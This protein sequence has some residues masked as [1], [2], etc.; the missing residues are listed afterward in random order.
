MG[1]QETFLGIPLEGPK[2]LILAPKRQFPPNKSA[3]KAYGSFSFLLAS[4]VPSGLDA[5][6]RK[7]SI[8]APFHPFKT[9]MHAFYVCFHEESDFRGPEAWNHLFSFGF[10]YISIVQCTST[11]Q[12]VHD[13]STQCSHYTHIIFFRWY[14]T[15]ETGRDDIIAKDIWAG[16]Y[17]VHM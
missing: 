10:F 13:I 4:K 2:I 11:L 17:N 16:N 14:T 6:A 8:S 15:D 12:Y 3:T 9:S 5:A 1:R 7:I